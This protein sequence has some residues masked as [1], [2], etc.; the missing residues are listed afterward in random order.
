[1]YFD[2]DYDVIDGNGYDRDG[3]GDHDYDHH[4]DY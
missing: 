1:M 3:N 4:Q 2:G